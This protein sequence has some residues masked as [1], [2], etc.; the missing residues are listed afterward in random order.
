MNRDSNIYSVLYASIMVIL[1]AGVLASVSLL[2][3]EKQQANIDAE[4]M[5]NILRAAQV[6]CP[7]EEAQ[8]MY[9]KFIKKT[10]VINTKGEIIEGSDA[11]AIDM[12]KQVKL[13][14]DKRTLPVFVFEKEGVGTKYVVPVYGGGMWGP[15]WGFLAFN[16]DKNTIYGATFDHASETPGLGAEIASIHF[17][18]QFPQKSIFDESGQFTSISLIKGGAKKGDLHAVDAIS[19]GT[20]TSG[21]LTETLRNCLEDYVQFFKSNKTE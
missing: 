8:T 13:S 12:S 11:F 5:Q 10:I 17:Q 9:D 21:K 4:K 7:R 14:K 1:V 19:G 20:V 16:S 18:E 3:K 6:E 2:L 15:I